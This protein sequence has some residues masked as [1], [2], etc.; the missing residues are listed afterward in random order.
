[1]RFFSS[2]PSE[3]NI[4]IEKDGVVKHVKRKELKDYSVERNC[5]ALG[6]DNED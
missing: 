2:M 1:M 6:V 4:R 5:I 3:A